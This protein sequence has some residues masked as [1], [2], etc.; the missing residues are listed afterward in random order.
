[1]D[2]ARTWCEYSWRHDETIVQFVVDQT[3]WRAFESPTKSED[4]TM[5]NTKSGKTL[6]GSLGF[7]TLFLWQRK[8]IG[9]RSC[10]FLRQ[11]C[12]KPFIVF[13]W[14]SAQ[15][16]KKN[17]A[18]QGAIR[19]HFGRLC[20]NLSAQNKRTRTQEKLAD[21]FLIVHRSRYNVDC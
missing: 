19:N 21:K 10:L 6:F 4:I 11:M 17:L 20:A 15:L 1:M 13:F 18:N 3:I 5:I 14:K 8:G 9:C 7:T 2:F 16:T 12:P